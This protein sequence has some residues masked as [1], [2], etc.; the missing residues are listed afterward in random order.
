MKSLYVHLPF[1]RQKCLYCAFPV[2]AT[3]VNPLYLSSLHTDLDQIRLKYSH[4]HSLS[5]LYLGGGTPTLLSD[6]QLTDLVG[7]IHSLW[8]IDDTTEISI[9]CDPGTLTP[10]KADALHKLGVN[11]VSIG[12]QLLDDTILKSCGR[13]HTVSQFW[14]TVQMLLQAGYRPDQLAVDLILGLPHV[15]DTIWRETVHNIVSFSPGHISTYFLT[16]EENTPFERMYREYQPP[17]PAEGGVVEMY[18]TADA[19]M[20]TAGYSHYEI[21]NYAKKDR[22]CKHSLVYWSGQNE[23]MAVGMGAASYVNR[24]RLVRPRKMKEYM[25]WVDQKTPDP[26]PET[27]LD[28]LKN[29]LM[30]QLRRSIGINLQEY[31]DSFGPLVARDIEH[32]LAPFRD[33]GIVTNTDTNWRLTVP[34]GFLVSSGVISEL[35][36]E[37]E[38][39]KIERINE[40]QSRNG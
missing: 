15:T 36:L 10:S 22:E 28:T 19:V 14:D 39:R 4:I 23:Y 31:A 34:K 26:A 3:P 38:R 2:L 20:Q 32:C 12:C 13:G 6:R 37:V 33:A 18:E 5:T 16:L 40:T 9:E 29:R 27:P 30:Y 21:S 24:V 17:L 11:R 1:C 25:Q 35:F 7:K 8:T